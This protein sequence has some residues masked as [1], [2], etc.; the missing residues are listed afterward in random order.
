MLY[1]DPQR[2]R[3]AG[4][5]EGVPEPETAAEPSVYPGI[6]LAGTLALLAA[7]ASDQV[8]TIWLGFAQSPVPP[9]LVAVGLGLAI[10]NAIGLPGTYDAGLRFCV[11]RVLRVG[12]ALL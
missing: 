3:F 4:A 6:A 11:Q 1:D 7:A 2:F 10:R 8:G 12:V 5:M 9:A